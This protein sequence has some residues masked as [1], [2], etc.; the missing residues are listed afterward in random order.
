M[1]ARPFDMYHYHYRRKGV[2]GYADLR[3]D[4]VV[5]IAGISRDLTEMMVTTGVVN[6]SENMVHCRLRAFI[7]VEDPEAIRYAQVGHHH[8][9]AYGDVREEMEALGKVLGVTVH[10][11]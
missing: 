11:V 9:M 4:E 1:V 8:G 7:D 6:R 10:S 3:T 5:T 2:T